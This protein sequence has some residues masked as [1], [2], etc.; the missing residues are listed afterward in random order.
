MLTEHRVGS[1]QDCQGGMAREEAARTKAWRHGE[2]SQSGNG[3]SSCKT[4]N[5]GVSVIGRRER[6][7]SVIGRREARHHAV[8]E[9]SAIRALC[10]V[11]TQHIP[12]R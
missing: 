11:M 7:E 4:E 1:G 5:K 3:C 12:L 10:K 9:H 2:P 8:G 6:Q